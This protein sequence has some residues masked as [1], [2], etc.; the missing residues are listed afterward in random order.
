[1]TID[2]LPADQARSSG[3]WLQCPAC[4][5][6]GLP[7]I[8]PHGCPACHS[9]GETSALLVAYTGDALRASPGRAGAGIW[10]RWG[11][12][13]PAVPEQF[14]RTHGEGSSPLVSV[15]ELSKLTGFERLYLKLESINPTGS[16]K[17]RFHAVSVA[18]ARALGKTGVVASSTGNHGLA[19]SAYAA[20]HGLRSVVIANPRMPLVLQRAI[21][22]TGGLPL[23]ADPATGVQIMGALVESG[24]WLPAAS[25]WPMPFANPYGIEGYKTIAYEIVEDLAGEEPDWILVP[26]AGGDLLCGVWRG[27]AEEALIR[28]SE[29]A[30]RLCACQP[31]GAAPLVA[32]LDRGLQTVPP[33]ARASSIALS[34]ADPVTGDLSLEAIHRTDGCALAVS[35]EQILNAG[36]QLAGV[37][38]LAE[39]SSAASLAGLKQLGERFPA[40][41]EQ[42]VV[43]VVTSSAIKWL[44][45]YGAAATDAAITVAGV[46]EGLDVIARHANP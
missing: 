6:G 26:T 27:L 24:E 33:L 28:G 18:M 38:I 46:S 42:I 20:L 5:F 44:D 2:T 31:A 4:G 41:R 16:H 45:D 12:R 3:W 39:P 30:T 13:L 32:A 19:M 29:L 36:R 25:V 17:D 43:C 22:F 15:P 14:R 34:I 23:I 35:D 9:H 11:S 37:G 10:E 40:A 21:R 1:M 8:Y 7:D